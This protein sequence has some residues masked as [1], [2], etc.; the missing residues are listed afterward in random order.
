MPVAAVVLGSIA[1]WLF[2]GQISDP[3]SKRRTAAFASLGEFAA[4]EFER[5]VSG[6]RI[7]LVYDVPNKAAADDPRSEARIELNAV[8]ALAFK[9]RLAPKGKYD[10][11]PDIK[12]PR[13]AMAMQSEWSGGTFQQLLDRPET[14]LVLFNSLPTLTPAQKNQITNRLG[15]IIVVGTSL[16]DIKAA[17]RAGLVHL[18]VASRV[19][20]PP[21]PPGQ[22]TPAAWARRVYVTVTPESASSIQ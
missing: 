16:P 3:A 4:D 8:Q 7:Q 19:P 11:A 15:K 18:A 10:F 2:Y 1:V 17:V 13:S 22:D 12:L 21:A 6:G 14:V 5:R 9:K 20:A